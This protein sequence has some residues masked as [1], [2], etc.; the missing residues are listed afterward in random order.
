MPS[1]DLIKRQSEAFINNVLAFSS[2]S[3]ALEFAGTFRATF[4]VP[5]DTFDI[6]GH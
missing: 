4:R 5:T 1:V 3:L 6:L 2:T